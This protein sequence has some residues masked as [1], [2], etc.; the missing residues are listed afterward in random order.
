MKRHTKDSIM[1]GGD[2]LSKT[3]IDS[4]DVCP[5]CKFMGDHVRDCPNEPK[6]WKE[7]KEHYIDLSKDPSGCCLKCG[8]PIC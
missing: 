3:K 5:L 4:N 1:L 7:R 6:A 2:I 8:E